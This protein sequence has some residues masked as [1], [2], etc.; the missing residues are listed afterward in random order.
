MEMKGCTI[1]E[2]V[3]KNGD[4]RF[5]RRLHGLQ[6]EEIKEQMVQGSEKLMRMAAEFTKK[7]KTGPAR[8][9]AGNAAAAARLGISPPRRRRRRLS[10]TSSGRPPPSRLPSAASRR[11]L[12]GRCSEPPVR[13]QAARPPSR[14][15]ASR[16][17]PVGRLPSPARRPLLGRPPSKAARPPP[18]RPAARPPP[19]PPVPIDLEIDLISCSARNSARLLIG[20]APDRLDLSFGSARLGS[21]S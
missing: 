13:L 1:K 8:L 12:A 4:M 20:S 6:P 15:S 7:I 3:E 10:F 18:S 17:P 5:R 16:P 11:S 19:E 14:P 21:V 9:T 2:F